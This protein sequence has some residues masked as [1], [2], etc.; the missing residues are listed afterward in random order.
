MSSFRPGWLAALATACSLVT[1][2][3]APAFAKAPDAKLPDAKAAAVKPSG[4]LLRP[5]VGMRRLTEDEYRRSIADAFGSQI[6][7]E[8]RFEPDVRRDGL[9]AIGAGQAAISSSGMEQYYAMASGISAQIAGANGRKTFLPCS[10]ASPGAADDACA[11][12]FFVK[13]GRLLYR[14]PLEAGELKSLVATAHRAATSSKD[15]YIGVEETLTTMLTSPNYLF[16]IERSSDMDKDG[17]AV[18]DDYSRASRLSFL[19]WDAPPDDELLRAAEH[20]DLSNREGLGRQGDRLAGSS[21]LSDGMSAFFNDMLQMDLFRLQ[22]KDPARFPKYSQVLAVDARQQTI[23][24]ILDLVIARQGDYRDIFT[25]RDTFL[26]RTLAMVYQ[27]PYTSNAAWTRYTFPVSSGR[28]GV[29]TQISFLSLFAHPAQS[30]PTKRGVALNEI[31]LCTPIPTPPADVDFSAVNGSGP[32]RKPTARL[33][34]EQ[35]RTNPTCATCHRIM[36]PPGLTLEKF[37]ALG[38]ARETEDGAPIDAKSEIGGK[39]IEGP[40][41][42]GQ[43]LHD[44]PQ[45]SSCVV[46]NLYATGVGRAPDYK[47]IDAMAKTFADG[48]Y[49]IPAFLTAAAKS[50]RFFAVPKS[51]TPPATPAAAKPPIKTSD[52]I[53]SKSARQTEA[54]KESRP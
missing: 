2:T 53:P 40:Q 54:Q 7:V 28:S 51:K 32:D 26:T 16:R 3:A 9:I 13:Y 12:R 43:M 14:R 38:Q 52:E 47:V 23:R 1:L 25:T 5:I 30:S 49:R 37:D 21:R 20:G 46:R 11:A 48:G 45:A 8:G 4:E 33:R 50:D 35:H 19:F 42:L 17:L 31:F 36:D 44:N 18:L 34:L 24:T 10:P 22:T 41:G 27:V 15:F 29:M 6:K 39:V